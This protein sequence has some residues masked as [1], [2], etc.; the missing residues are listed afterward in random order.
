MPKIKIK[1]HDVTDC[2]AA[3]LASICR[4]YK[5][6]LPIA[7][8]RQYASTDIIGTNILGLVEA[9]KKLGF[10]AKGVR[11]DLDS[12]SQIPKPAIAHIV[13]EGQLQHYVVIYDVTKTSIRY[14][15]PGDGK[16]HKKKLEEFKKLW[17]G[18]LVILLPSESFSKRDETISIYKRFWFLLRPHKYI[19]YQALVG[20]IIYTLLGFST[21]IFIQKLTDYVLVSGNT[22]LLNLM[23]VIMIILLILQIVVG[24]IK[25]IFIIKTGQQIDARLILGYY[26]HLLTL[27]QQFFDRMRVGEI[28]SRI[29]DAVKIRTLIN[30][31]SL[32]ITVNALILTFSMALMYLYYWKLALVVTAILPLYFGIYYI[33]NRLNK[34]TE[35]KVMV[36]A[37]KLES[38]LVESLNSIGTIKRFGLEDFANIKTESAFIKVLRNTFKSALNSVFSNNSTTF[39]SSL[40]TIILLWAGAYYVINREITAGELMSFYAI[41]G[42]FTKP[43][44]SL[45]EA[46]KQIQ[47]AIIASDRLFEIMDLEREQTG[48]KVILKKESIGNIKFNNVYF[49]YGT[50]ADIFKG[51][52]L[53]IEKNKVTAIIGSSGS[54]KTTLISLLQNI[55]AIQDGN[56]TIG[57]LNIKYI[58]NTSL[59]ELVSVVPQK[60]DLFAGT[61]TENIGVGQYV[62]DE[63]RIIEICKSIG[64]LEFIEKLPEGFDTYLGE[65]GANLSGGQKQRIAIARALY[66]NP[67]ILVLDEAT[68]S[69]DSSSENYIQNTIQ[70]LKDSGKTV[71]VIAHRL[72]TI[73]DSDTIVVL[74]DGAVVETGTHK[75]LYDQ[76]GAYHE[77]WQEQLPRVYAEVEC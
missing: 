69:L 50:R 12:L 33:S 43:V 27:P 25:D 38:Q 70:K 24:V 22:K 65:N 23:G 64:V 11:G 45:V 9:A 14:M 67:E 42:Y 75:E 60:I 1:Q 21:S 29:N 26:K 32:N 57:N 72:S 58:D 7:K 62:P 28:I 51:F 13:T 17:T 48:N 5:L 74:D 37:A 31:V 54:G 41:M 61:I 66:V 49:N 40:F 19:L 16:I 10:D 2:G 56:I 44:A 30:D 47:N 20:A 68:S 15:D 46:N 76:K 63:E 53:T 77:F 6:K 8:I 18:V 3:C 59:R 35:R 55:Y 52:N 73:V 4:F 71:I 39:I 36:N 34:Q